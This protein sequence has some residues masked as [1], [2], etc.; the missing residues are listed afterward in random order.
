MNKLLLLFLIIG[1]SDSFACTGIRLTAVNGAVIYA[2]TMEFGQYLQSKIIVLPR[3]KEFKGTGPAGKDNGL[4][5]KSKYAVVGANALGVDVIL[6][7]VNEAGLAGGL[8]YFPG[9]AEF[10]TV[11]AKEAQRSMGS[12]ELLT[13]I[14]TNF[15]TVE[16]VKTALPTIKVS[17]VPLAQW[18]IAPPDHVIVHDA[19]GN[20]IVVE[21]VKGMLTVY[22]NPLGVITNSPTFDWH[23]TNLR[24][25]INLSSMNGASVTID[26][27]VLKPFG[28]GSGM[29]GLPGD[30][31]PP[32]RFVRAVAFSQTA[33]QGKTEQES[34][35]TAFHILN[36]F[37]IPKGV[38]RDGGKDN[39]V[40]DYT[41]W[42]SL[43]DTKNKRFY[44]HTY[45][46]RQIKMVDLGKMDLNAREVVILPMESKQEIVDITPQSQ[47]EL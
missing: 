36:L 43:S 8:F 5:W 1:I 4:Q 22:D 6:D 3:N 23:I 19:A 16:E 34:I 37:D 10:Q 26:G 14:L 35:D 39:Y 21:Y 27:V 24:N 40:T 7:G 38:I 44:F 17:K 45:D 11:T 42:T 25:Y 20:S 33:Q 9:Y 46:N 28:Q 30:F 18:K 15:K 41:Q 47:A 31:T 12:W 29:L 2:R 32:S 13:W